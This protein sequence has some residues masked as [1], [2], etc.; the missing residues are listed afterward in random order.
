MNQFRDD[1]PLLRVED[2]KLGFAQ[3]AERL[4]RVI[5][6]Q[7]AG[8]GLVVGI[9]GKWGSGKST[10]INLTKDALQRQGD[11][12]PEVIVFSPWLVGDRGAL[13]ANLFDEL[14]TAAIRIEPNEAVIDKKE[15]EISLLQRFQRRLI[16][17]EHWRLKQKELLKKSIGGKLRA[18]GTIAGHVGKLG[19]MAG[20]PNAALVGTTI[21]HS[22]NIASTYLKGG[23][24]SARKS[25]LVDALKFLSRRIVVF[26][27]DLDRLEPREAIEMLRLIRAVADFPNIIYV[28]SYDRDIVAQT[29]SKSLQINDGGEFL[30]K[31][32]QVSF[33]VPRP[34]TYDLRRWFNAEINSLFPERDEDDG[35]NRSLAKARLEQVI[36]YWGAIYLKT[37]RDVMR[38]LNGLLLHG[39]PISDHIYLPDMVW[40]QL[41]RVCNPTLYEWTEEYLTELAAVA[42]GRAITDATKKDMAHELKQLMAGV[43]GD[44]GLAIISLGLVLPGVDAGSWFGRD[45]D[46]RQVF[47]NVGVHSLNEF[48]ADKRLGSPEHY[49]FY[50]AFSEPAGA[51]R[52]EQAELFISVAE[53]D[54]P[55]AVEMLKDFLNQGRPQGGSMVEVL[56]DRLSIWSDRIPEAA[57]P[58]IFAAIGEIMDEAAAA[59][60]E[61][62]FGRHPAWPPAEHVV[63]VLLGRTSGELRAACL[64]TLFV[65]G[66]ALSWLTYVLR[67]EIFSHGHF[68]D[69]MEPVDQ[70]LLSHDEFEEVLG[71]MLDRYRRTPAEDLL[72]VPNLLYLLYA[73]QQGGGT[74]EARRWVEKVTT[75]DAGLLAF[76][77]RVRSCTSTSDRG[78][79]YP[80]RCSNL[81]NFLDCDVI[82]GRLQGIVGSTA[83]C[84]ADRRIAQK[85]LEAIE[86]GRE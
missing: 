84:N 67:N 47:N 33:R 62:D 14:T 40:L 77:P 46:Q 36:D 16:G 44:E 49:R 7:Y 31:I 83:A 75:T 76:L 28:L 56:I 85:M 81:R 61:S 52:D 34:E 29:L 50:F 66:K 5:V 2:D 59:S 79:V 37:P 78:V 12:S 25:A 30:E 70:R 71:G 57:I 68:G 53:E 11:E 9:E 39:V 55:T 72:R 41:V 1:R 20:E 54:P 38:A 21:K 13:L 19:V 60:M 74:D 35:P 45:A 86:Q 4:A 43:G 18:F 24:V 15:I 69:R 80:L 73:W 3:V 6:N 10:L 48:K 58:G 32:V 22:S 64:R 27:D 51:L 82:V 17:S 63:S 23:S 65:E 42:N 8:N 26:V